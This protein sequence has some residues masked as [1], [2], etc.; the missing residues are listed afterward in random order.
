VVTLGV[1][2]QSALT[3]SMAATS[4]RPR[5]PILPQTELGDVEL[6]V[7]PRLVGITRRR[8]SKPHVGKHARK[9]KRAAAWG[10]RADIA[11]DELIEENGRRLFEHGL[12]CMTAARHGTPRGMMIDSVRLLL[13]D[14]ERR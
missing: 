9:K 7:T 12:R 8:R 1:I 10:T 14:I 6:A 3:V 11:I 2:S 4:S 5:T 13:N